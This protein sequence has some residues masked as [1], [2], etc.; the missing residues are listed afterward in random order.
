MGT[1]NTGFESDGF[2]TLSTLHAKER[3]LLVG[4]LISSE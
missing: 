3:T 4:K 1:D 2:A